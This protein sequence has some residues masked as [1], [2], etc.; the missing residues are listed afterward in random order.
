MEFIKHKE[1]KV[2]ILVVPPYS[3]DLINN[4]EYNFD[5]VYIPED[6]YLDSILFQQTNLIKHIS[7]SVYLENYLNGF[8]N[9]LQ[10]SGF[11]IFLPDELDAFK[12]AD[13]QSYIFKFAQVE[14]SEEIYPNVVSEKISDT[15]F[16]K[17]FELNLVTA[18]SWFE[19][20][21]RDSAWAKVFFA[22]DAVI[23]EFSA[24]VKLDNSSKNP[25]LYYSIDSLSVADVYQMATDVGIKY[26]GYL[27]DYLMNNYIREHYPPSLNPS[28]FFHYE[29]EQKMLFPFSEGFQEITKE[30]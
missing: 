22:E 8:I 28:I 2:A 25:I 10:K 13:S 19:F 6:I 5:S 9:S 21:A 16:Y 29:A 30:K 26:A 11:Q 20:E 17:V 1:Y 3:L 15:K 27:T 4:N 23:D 24:E 18:N 12:D 7:D 14:L